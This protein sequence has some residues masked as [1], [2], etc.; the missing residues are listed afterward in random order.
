MTKLDSRVVME[1]GLMLWPQHY[2]VY[3]AAFARKGV[4]LKQSIW[5]NPQSPFYFCINCLASPYP[6]G[7][8][9][10]QIGKINWKKESFIAQVCLGKEKWNLLKIS[11]WA[12]MFYGPVW[13]QV[14]L[15]LP[16][17]MWACDVYSAFISTRLKCLSSL[18]CSTVFSSVFL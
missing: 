9:D 5:F 18:L 2:C 1:C 12:C 8:E 13:A 3:W 7:H 11:Y 16:S 6:R 10:Q 15:V 17:C 4:K 14:R